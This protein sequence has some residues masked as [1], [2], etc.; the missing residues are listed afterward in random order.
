MGMA[1][2]VMII[3]A[4]TSG[5]LDSLPVDKVAAFEKAFL[6]H[7]ADA[8]PEV[9]Q[10]LEADGKELTEA[11]RKTLDAAVKAVKAQMGL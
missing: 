4:A 1:D 2:Q 3:Y 7:M 10:R 11:E 6:R 9:G 8:S 5:G